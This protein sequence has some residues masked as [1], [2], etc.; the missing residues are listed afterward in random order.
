MIIAKRKPFEEIKESLENYGS[1]LIAGC[2]TCVA[3]CLAG[4]EKEVGILA[5]Q[6]AIASQ[7]DGQPLKI[8][9]VT[10]ERQCDKE[11]LQE[12]RNKVD[13]YDAIL[14]LAC[15]VGVQFLSDMYRDKVVLPGVDTSFIG[16]NDEVGYWT[17]RCRMCN[18]C[19]LAT[20]GAVCP[21]TM[22]PKGL[23]NGPC[24]GTRDG[25]CEVDQEK[26]CAWALIYERLEKTDRLDQIR[27]TM[28]PRNHSKTGS[29]AV[30]SHKSYQRRY[31]AGE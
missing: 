7:V 14:S 8:G 10:I 12:L 6:L 5:S 23:L 24:S 11:F 16:A 18:Q 28:P 13:D 4:G 21:V 19:Y 15:G 31:T 27:E 9:E 17:E 1:V 26:A 20:T 3:V 25:M 30:L 29:P 22:C 2:G